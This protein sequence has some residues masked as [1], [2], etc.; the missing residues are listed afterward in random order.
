MTKELED[1]GK[2]VADQINGRLTFSNP[3]D[4][5]HC[6]MAFAL[7]DGSTDG[8]LY[9]SVVDAKRHTDEWKTWYV[10]MGGV[11]GG[12]NARDCALMLVFH[13]EARDASLS[14]ANPQ[15]VPFLSVKGMDHY[16]QRLGG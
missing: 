3:W 14:Q 10:C 8:V 2:R 5:K 1:A 13:R 16:R 9:D 15:D 7:Q 12:T 6:W 11:L 4:I